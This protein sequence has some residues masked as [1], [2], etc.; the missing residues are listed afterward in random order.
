[1]RT[2][3]EEYLRELRAQ[4][5]EVRADLEARELEDPMAAH[6][7]VMAATRSMP[8]VIHKT[9]PNA[10]V[11]PPSL[12]DD[13]EPPSFN[14]DQVEQLA[15]VLSEFRSDLLQAVDEAMTPLRERIAVLEGKLDLLTILLGSGNSKSFEASETIRKLHVR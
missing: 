7:E 14:D 12:D 9:L 1:V 10:R 2:L 6:E 8:A 13:G 4:A 5:A 15:S 3:D 11:A